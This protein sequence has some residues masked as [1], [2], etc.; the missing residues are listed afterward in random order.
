MV[1]SDF[2]KQTSVVMPKPGVPENYL[3]PKLDIGVI[4]FETAAVTMSAEDSNN[5]ELLQNQA[6]E[7]INKAQAYALRILA[8]AEDKAK[9]VIKQAISDSE[10]ICSEKYKY[11]LE[12][13]FKE[14]AARGYKGAQSEVSKTL[15]EMQILSSCLANEK[16]QITE[17]SQNLILD[18]A[19]VIAK[20]VSGDCFVNDEKV[21]LSMFRRTVKEMPG[22]QKLTVTISDK[23]YKLMS[24]DPQKLLD[25][26]ENFSCI[27][28][29][30]DKSAQEGTLKLETA[31]M[32]LDAGINAQ[33]GL[34]KKEIAKS[35]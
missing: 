18:L 3:L 21:F 31:I 11:A 2:L 4:Q 10:E 27:K 34:L 1:L 28:L 26:A 15:D 14:G 35:F 13:G 20:K 8:E 19:A 29:C 30:I 23:D 5:A 24:F 22:A 17:D 33:I 16:R 9:A 7:I 6:D 32:L 25:S 12:S